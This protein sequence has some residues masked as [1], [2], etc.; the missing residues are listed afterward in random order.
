MIQVAYRVAAIMI[1][2][3]LFLQCSDPP[4]TQEI[5]YT[6]LGTTFELA[7]QQTAIIKEAD[8]SI[9]MSTMLNDTRCHGQLDCIA[10]GFVEI[11]LYVN[12]GS[13]GGT[14]LT[15][16]KYG[17]SWTGESS[18]LA[19]TWNGYNFELHAVRPDPY[20]LVIFRTNT[21]PLPPWRITLRVVEESPKPDLLEPV[22]PVS[23]A[24][25]QITLDPFDLDSVAIVADTLFVHLAHGGG[26]KNHYYFMYM[27]P[28]EFAES[29]PVQASLYLRH[30]DNDDACRKDCQDE[31]CWI[32][33]TLRFDLNPI[34]ALHQAAYGT[35]GPILLNVYDYFT[36]TPGEKMQVLYSP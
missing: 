17:L 19:E 3:L 26:C 23:F 8:L 5:F 6:D 24:P 33:T 2:G 29:N 1:F 28:G 35:P 16:G 36:V 13:A 31:R 34:K 11:E 22:T 10:P 9:S 30:D 21:P 12:S 18:A 27:S 4:N 20:E 7:V 25:I 14:H 15:L 32:T